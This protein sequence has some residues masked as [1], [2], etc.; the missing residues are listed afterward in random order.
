MSAL[1]TRVLHEHGANLSL[2]GEDRHGRPLRARHLH[3]AQEHRDEARE[4]LLDAIRAA[5]FAGDH[6]HA[7]RLGKV[8]EEHDAADVAGGP[9]E[10]DDQD[11][12]ARGE[13]EKPPGQINSTGSGRGAENME[14]RERRLLRESAARLRGEPRGM[15]LSSRRALADW[16]RQH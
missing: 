2:F 8:L 13:P 7:G 16:L 5:H 9:E 15:Q 12:D 1:I 14:S 11:Q 10:L 3:E 6:E 4:H